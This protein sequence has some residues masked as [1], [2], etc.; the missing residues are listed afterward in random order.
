MRFLRTVSTRRLLAGLTAL[1]IVGVGG[2]AI[3]VAAAGNGSVP[4]KRSLASALHRALSAKPVNGLVAH[5]TFTN[6][7]IGSNN[8][9]GS[10][11]LLTGAP[12]RLWIG[13]GRIRLELQS[14]SGQDAQVVF[15]RGAFWVYDPAMN[16]VYRGKLPASTFKAPKSS[17][18]SKQKQDSVPTIAQIQKAIKRV[19][20]HLGISGATPTDVAGQ[21]AYRVAV[22]PKSNGGLIGDLKL[23]WDANHGVPLD[24]AVLAK[25]N[26]TPV[27]ELKATGI[28]YRHVPASVFTIKPPAGTK[29]VHVSVPKTTASGSVAKANAKSK[30]HAK[31]I[32]GVAAVQKHLSFTLAA[33]ASLA[34]RSRQ[35]VSLVGGSSH[36]GAMLFYGKG[37]SGIAV[38]E[39]P[40]SDGSSALPSSSGSGGNGSAGLT[41]PTANINGVTAQQLPTPLGTVLQFRRG[42]VSYLVLGSVTADTADAAARAL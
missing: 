22:S 7:L 30:K 9:Q 13:D 25:G 10:D 3:A 28:S 39:R 35:S 20:A 19:A 40:A 27:L 5:I 15:N 11:P 4:K 21:P 12:G 33:P 17:S 23:A 36:H 32:T 1:I 8:I 16:V 37:L 38:I 42:G 41:L 26:S 18:S 14:A 29:V 6:N 2:S 31:E 34:G 24:F